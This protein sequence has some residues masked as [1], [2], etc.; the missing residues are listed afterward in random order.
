ML[1]I[2]SLYYQIKIALL[3]KRLAIS[4]TFTR[5]FDLVHRGINSKLS[6]DAA[7]SGV[8]TKI[9]LQFFRYCRPS[10]KTESLRLPVCSLFS[11]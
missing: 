4:L 1:I 9:D 5:C 2:R 7:I 6:K 3:H 8:L 10:Y 11:A